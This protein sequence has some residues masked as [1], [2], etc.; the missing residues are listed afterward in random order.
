MG[1]FDIKV[2]E[3]WDFTAQGFDSK[4]SQPHDFIATPAWSMLPI[5]G[6]P[7]PT[8]LVAVL[9]PT[10]DGKTMRVKGVAVGSLT[11]RVDC[12]GVEQDSTVNIVPPYDTI[13]VTGA[14]V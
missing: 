13:L 2:G 14:K 3:T 5:A 11:L 4:A 6:Q 9:G 1:S 8:S 7:A 12:D 10:P